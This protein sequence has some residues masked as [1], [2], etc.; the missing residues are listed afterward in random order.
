MILF[1]I[2]TQVI[3]CMNTSDELMNKIIPGISRVSLEEKEAFLSSNEGRELDTKIKTGYFQA[4]TYMSLDTIKFH[5]SFKREKINDFWIRIQ[6]SESFLKLKHA[7]IREQ[8]KIHFCEYRLLNEDQQQTL[9][10]TS[11]SSLLYSEKF[12]EKTKAAWRQAFRE[13]A[14]VD[15][16]EARNYLHEKISQFLK[17]ANTQFGFLFP[18]LPDKDLFYLAQH[19]YDPTCERATKQQRLEQQ[20]E[21]SKRRHEMWLLRDKEDLLHHWT[22]K[23]A[24]SRLVNNVVTSNLSEYMSRIADAHTFYQF[25]GLSTENGGW[26]LDYL[27][28][29]NYARHQESIATAKNVLYVL[30]KP[31]HAFFHEYVQL[32][33]Y[34]KNMLNI[35]LRALIPI[36]MVGIFLVLSY[37]LVMPFAIHELLEIVMII[38]TLYL[39]LAGASG[40]VMLKNHISSACTAYWWGD[41][42]K[43]PAFQVNERMLSAFQNEPKLAQSIADYYTNS[44]KESDQIERDFAKIPAGCLTSDELDSR[45]NNLTRK[46]TLLLEWYDIHSNLELGADKTPSI[47]S[48]RLHLDG[49]TTYDKFSQESETFIEYFLDDVDKQIDE[50]RQQPSIHSSSNHLFF[51]RSSRAEAQGKACVGQLEKIAC[52]ETIYPRCV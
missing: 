36:I 51:S 2:Y 50:I 15:V 45:K 37:S 21:Q 32:A 39:S 5:S 9:A 40:Y 49:K 7:I 22:I 33:R 41:M 29:Y 42:Y 19:I 20:L 46:S 16:T 47:V 6:R 23:G 48:N 31:L 4:P 1:D 13:D 44:I 34:E 27:D 14:N 38:P 30:M 12:S 28:L 52:I 18:R 25:L 17:H 43:T 10:K 3:D 8:L 35:V 26:E 24:L 11:Y